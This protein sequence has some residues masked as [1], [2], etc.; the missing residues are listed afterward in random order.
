[1][2]WRRTRTS[3]WLGIVALGLLGGGLCAA[4]LAG[5]EARCSE[6]V[7]PEVVSPDDRYVARVRAGDCLEVPPV[8]T[9][10]EVARR[11]GVWLGGRRWQ[12]VFRFFGTPADVTVDWPSPEGPHALLI[13]YEHCRQQDGQPFALDDVYIAYDYTHRPQAPPFDCP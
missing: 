13:A 9:R 10:V 8:Y 4:S 3:V 6:Y 7:G 12:T 11:D 1:M 5:L 2:R